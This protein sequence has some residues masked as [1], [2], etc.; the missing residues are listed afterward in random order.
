[1]YLYNLHSMTTPSPALTYANPPTPIPVPGDGNPSK[2]GRRGSGSGNDV[3]AFAGSR[4]KAVQARAQL[5]ELKG[6]A[7]QAAAAAEP[8]SPAKLQAARAADAAAGALVDEELRR[9]QVV[10]TTATPC[11]TQAAPT[12]IA[13]S[14]PPSRVSSACSCVLSSTTA[15][16]TVWAIKTAATYTETCTTYTRGFLQTSVAAICDPSLYVNAVAK[17]T[18]PTGTLGAPAVEATR[19]VSDRISCCQLCATTYNC[20][21]WKWL[22]DHTFPADAAHF[23]GGFDP[24]D[25]GSC[26]FGYV[27]SLPSTP[28]TSGPYICPNTFGHDY[29]DYSQGQNAS[30]G[31]YES[32][33]RQGWNQGACGN[34]LNLY[35]SNWECGCNWAS[36]Y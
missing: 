31:Q 32:L 14:Y 24:W 34:A 15:T 35:E 30:W 22:P 4:D 1:M 10:T 12:W 23:I 28:V 18:Q 33:Y 9:R 19:P 5:A 26:V 25:T 3:G 20:V 8:T 27:A 11:P 17:P 29:L 2:K 36:C 21:Y 13:A 7:A 16:S 6:R